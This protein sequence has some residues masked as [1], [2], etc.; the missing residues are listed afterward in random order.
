MIFK[1]ILPHIYHLHMEDCYDLCMHF[2]RYQEHCEG[3]QWKDQIFTLL[4]LMECYAKTYGDG[5]FT[6]PNDWAGF[7]VPSS[8]LITLAEANLPDLNKYDIAMRALIKTAREEEKDD[9]FYFIGTCDGDDFLEETLD[10]EVAHGLYFT[11]PEYRSAMDELLDAMPHKNY[12]KA[13]SALQAM[14]YHPAVCRDEIHAYACTGP[15]VALKAALSPA[16][17]KPF[18]KAYKEQRKIHK[19]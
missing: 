14:K 12:D 1:K 8:T 18:I 7:N 19:I 16:I 10:H 2:V 9:K 4:E 6:Y 15:D 11:T 3:L 5:A 13:W 17:C